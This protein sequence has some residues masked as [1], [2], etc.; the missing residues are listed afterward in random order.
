MTKI[1]AQNSTQPPTLSIDWEAYL[2]YLENEDISEE[3]KRELIETLWSIMVTFVDL[4][5]G[6]EPT[7]QAMD[8]KGIVEASQSFLSAAQMQNKTK[9]QQKEDTQ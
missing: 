1:S 8:A 6:I 5:F 2:P 4:G 7:Q 9:A 3:K